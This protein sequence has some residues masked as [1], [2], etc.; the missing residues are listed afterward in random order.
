MKN[1]KINAAR[2]REEG[3]DGRG[4][5]RWAGGELQGKSDCEIPTV[6]SDCCE[7]SAANGGVPKDN[8][9]NDITKGVGS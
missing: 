6:S 8:T 1:A 2:V 9:M 3:T 5:S 4:R 7:P